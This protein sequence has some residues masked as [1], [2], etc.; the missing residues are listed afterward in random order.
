MY[1]R[2]FCQVK[3]KECR[4]YPVLKLKK[5]NGRFW[6]CCTG[7]GLVNAKNRDLVIFIVFMHVKYNYIFSVLTSL[8][9]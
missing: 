3:L 4:N 2:R 8:P 7:V 5:Q 6:F 1:K 9:P